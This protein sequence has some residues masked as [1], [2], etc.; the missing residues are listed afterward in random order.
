MTSFRSPRGGSKE[1]AV[2]PDKEGNIRNGLKLT[3]ERARRK[4]RKATETR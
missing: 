2:I 1:G 4:G 3:S